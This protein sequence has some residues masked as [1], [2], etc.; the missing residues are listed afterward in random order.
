MDY[1][2]IVLKGYSYFLLYKL[3]GELKLEPFF[4]DLLEIAEM[5]KGERAEKEGIMEDN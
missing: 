4:F 3:V 5:K 2:L 1:I